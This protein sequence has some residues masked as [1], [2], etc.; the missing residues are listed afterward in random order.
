MQVLVAGTTR[1]LGGAL[2]TPRPRRLL[3]VTGPLTMKRMEDFDATAVIPKAEDFML[4]SKEAGKP[5]F[6][7]LNTNRMH[8]Y[9]RLN[10]KW[11]YA[12]RAPSAR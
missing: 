4:A 11:R 6:V 7:W 5:F 1:E 12:V 10:E 9:T 3:E 8:L 2:A